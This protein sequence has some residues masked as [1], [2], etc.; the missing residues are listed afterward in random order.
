MYQVG[1]R[2]SYAT[3]FAQWPGMSEYPQLWEG[4]VAAYAPFLGMTGS[5]VFDLSGWKNHGDLQGTAPSWSAGK[6]GSAVLL[7]GTD[8]C[9]SLGNNVPGLSV[10]AGTVIV[11]FKST[12]D[13]GDYQMMFTHRTVG[14]DDRIYLETRPDT[15]DFYIEFA[16]SGVSI[17][18]GVSTEN[19]NLWHMGVVTWNATQADGYLD[20]VHFGTDVDTIPSVTG[21]VYFGQNR[22]LSAPFAG[23][24]SLAQIYNRTLAASEVAQLSWNPFCD[25]GPRMMNL[26]VPAP[27]GIIRSKIAGGLANTTPLLGGMAA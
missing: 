10:S 4:L 25:L 8:E 27:T 3:G 12:G 11:W 16:E 7:P 5:Q 15:G 19:D 18:S 9:I 23:L 17:S 14:T 24:I 6:F 1:V 2:P 21:D 22:G 13:T 26:Y 20:G